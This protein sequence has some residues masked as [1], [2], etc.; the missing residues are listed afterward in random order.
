MAGFLVVHILV[1]F[2]LKRQSAVWLAEPAGGAAAAAWAGRAGGS[3]GEA[4]PWARVS[5]PVLPA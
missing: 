4:P 5:A 2:F 1:Y 3:A